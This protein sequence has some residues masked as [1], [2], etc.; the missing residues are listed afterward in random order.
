MV[1]SKSNK[2]ALVIDYQETLPINVNIII[3]V[4][5]RKCRRWRPQIFQLWFCFR[6]FKQATALGLFYYSSPWYI[7]VLLRSLLRRCFC[8]FLSDVVGENI[9]EH[10]FYYTGLGATGAKVKLR[11]RGFPGFLFPYS[12]A[13]AAPYMCY[14]S[15]FTQLPCN[16]TYASCLCHH[17]INCASALHTTQAYSTIFVLQQIVFP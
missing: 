5:T 16:L 14:I 10:Q 8:H 6:Q 9:V 13:C 4:T 1:G 7:S 17:Y 15:L 3:F 11:R 12:L 2:D